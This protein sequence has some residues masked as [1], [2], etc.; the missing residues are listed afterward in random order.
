[1]RRDK[2]YLKLVLELVEESNRPIPSVLVDAVIKKAC[3][4]H[5]ELEEVRFQ[6][7]AAILQLWYGEFINL[8]N[9]RLMEGGLAAGKITRITWSGYDLLDSLRNEE[10]QWSKG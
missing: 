6:A 9:G 2:K 3:E 5:G 7:Q 1:M 4:V 8:D 10:N